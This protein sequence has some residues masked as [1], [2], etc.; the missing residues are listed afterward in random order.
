MNLIRLVFEYNVLYISK[1]GSKDAPCQLAT[2]PF[3]G[4]YATICSHFCWH[5]SGPVS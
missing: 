4:K 2:H 1:N 3:V 5:T